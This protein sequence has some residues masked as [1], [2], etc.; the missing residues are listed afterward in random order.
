MEDY[1]KFLIIPFVFLLM[2]FLLF[3]RERYL[4]RK[5]NKSLYNW[6]V[7]TNFGKA[8]I[9]SNAISMQQN[10]ILTKQYNPFRN[11]KNV[12]QYF[13]DMDKYELTLIKDFLLTTNNRYSI[14][15]DE[16]I[17]KISLSTPFATM[18]LSAIVTQWNNDAF[19]GSVVFLIAVLIFI[20]E[21]EKERNVREALL[22]FIDRA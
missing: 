19:I 18:L 12:D 22:M 14:F 5:V 1:Y 20:K 6:I 11:L 2:K 3:I 15:Q 7:I 8:T 16:F 9:I 21:Y 13:K 10:G 4:L 17:K